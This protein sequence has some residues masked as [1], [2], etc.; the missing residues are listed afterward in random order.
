MS[1]SDSDS[2]SNSE[3]DLTEDNNSIVDLTQNLTEDN[4]SEIDLTQNLTEDNNSEIGSE[5]IR[6]TVNPENLI[7]ES[8]PELIRANARIFSPRPHPPW[9]RIPVHHP[10]NDEQ[11]TT[12]ANPTRYP[13]FRYRNG[14]PVPEPTEEK[15]I[16][17][18]IYIECIACK[19]KMINTICYPCQHAILCC[20]CARAWG[21][22]QNICP[23]CKI[24]IVSIERIYF[25][26]TEYQLCP[27]SPPPPPPLSP[28]APTECVRCNKRARRILKRIDKNPDSP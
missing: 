11:D 8:H 26:Y 15:A 10:T 5:D 9:S 25:H 14:I 28:P 18:P 27:S 1:S 12:T 22:L 6:I 21:Q 7:E 2:D 13:I 17:N 3:T 19:E 16:T 20:E 23:L 24:G 4:N